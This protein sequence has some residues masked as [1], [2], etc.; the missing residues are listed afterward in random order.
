MAPRRL[1][2]PT[3]ESVRFLRRL[4]H[5]AADQLPARKLFVTRGRGSFGRTL[6]NEAAI[7]DRCFR[8]R[9]YELVDPGMLP[10]AE[11]C[12]LFSA[13]THIAGP[14][15]AAFSL[16]CLGRL[17]LSVIELHSPHYH[18]NCFRTAAA[19]LGARHAAFN[20]R[21]GLFQ[22][23]HW[24]ANFTLDAGAVADWLATLPPGMA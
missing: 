9:G 17:P 18:A 5:P 20:A 1:T 11:Q 23:P 15:G 21:R 19:A 3:E 10:F 7:Y 13:S 14:H 6:E 24:T 2:C 12:A 4:R 16:F 8:P 22:P